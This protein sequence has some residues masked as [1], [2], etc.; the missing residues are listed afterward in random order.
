MSQTPEELEAEVELQREQ[1]GET[2]DQLAAKLDVKTQAQARVHEIADRA[3]TD[4]GGKK[5]P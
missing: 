5:P 2:V 4:T 1:L 3:T